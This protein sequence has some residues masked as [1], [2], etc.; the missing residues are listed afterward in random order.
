[1]AA[2]A[3]T[4]DTITTQQPDKKDDVDDLAPGHKILVQVDSV[5]PD[6]LVVSYLRNGKTFQG[7][8]LDATK[9]LLMEN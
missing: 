4:D 9:R 7:A 2:A 5:L 3:V 1:M 6:I 8:L